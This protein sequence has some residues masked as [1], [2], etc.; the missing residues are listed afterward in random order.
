MERG[1]PCFALVMNSL[2]LETNTLK[3]RIQT[4]A[5]HTHTASYQQLSNRI[6]LDMVATVLTGTHLQK[7]V[8]AISLS[9][10]PSSTLH[11]QVIM[12]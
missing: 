3:M 7:R 8:V 6:Y 4:S 12:Q 9:Y 2:V 11:P 10:S 5:P 1:Q